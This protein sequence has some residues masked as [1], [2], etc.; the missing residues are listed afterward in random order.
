MNET[1]S[2]GEETLEEED[3]S[4]VVPDTEPEKELSP[5]ERERE[6]RASVRKEL[7][8]Q[9]QIMRDL[10]QR[11]KNGE[12]LT[13][14]IEACKGQID[15]L[16]KEL[17]A[18]EEGGHTTFLAA[19]QVIAPKMNY[20]EKKENLKL[21]IKATK[22]EIT[23][24]EDSLYEPN[25]T[26]QVRDEIIGEISRLKKE[27]EDLAEEMNAI[28]QFNHTRF[29]EAREENKE[30]IIKVQEEQALEVEKDSLRRDLEKA[31]EDSNLDLANEIIAKIA[32]VEDKIKN[33][34]RPKEDA[35]LE[36]F[37]DNQEDPFLE[38]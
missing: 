7:R 2:E 32:N 11:V 13:D 33:L 14:D 4:S 21:E 31:N 3:I 8:D 1:E 10:R 35:F 15:L 36:Q 22:K 17:Q 18:I 38:R 9:R 37:E 34:S 12:N 5:R 29:V 26:D 30:S 6:S 23:E 27:L 28:L 16:Y 19:K 24:L 25:L 20:S